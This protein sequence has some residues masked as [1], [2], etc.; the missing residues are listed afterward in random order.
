MKLKTIKQVIAHNQCIGCGLCTLDN[1]NCMIESA[2]MLRPDVITNNPII[3]ASCP[4]KGYDLKSFGKDLFGEVAYRPELGYY[5]SIHMAHTN[6]ESFLENASSG[7][8][9]TEIALFLLS[10]GLVDG[11]ITTRFAIVDNKVRTEVFI[12]KDSESLIK[13]QGSKY[14]PTSTLSIIKQLEPQKRYLLIGTPCQIAGF[15]LY[16]RHIESAK[17]QIPYTI[18]NFCGGYRDYRELDYFVNDVAHVKN[19][20]FFRHRGGGQPGSMKI[21]GKKGEQ[22]QYPYPDYAKLS[23]YVKNERCT[24]CMD[25]TGELADFS[26]GDAWLED[27]DKSAP[28]SIIIAR[29]E[30]ASG[31]IQELVGKKLITEGDEIDA[32]KVIESQYS[33]ITS[34]K[35]RQY[36]RIRVRDF[37]LLPSPFWYDNYTV[38]GGNYLNEFRIMMSKIK[39]KWLNNY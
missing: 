34:K 14:C 9:M 13:G 36:K 26:C 31:L 38:K 21:I 7:G 30:F 17:R 33:N 35:Y 29:S 8:L 15:R 18:A 24:L 11:V 32:D 16:S 12:A 10:K 5:R 3:E 27:R 39:A 19:V 37:M 23:N 4:S 2:G 22:F 25:A 6:R 20:K 28:W 1:G